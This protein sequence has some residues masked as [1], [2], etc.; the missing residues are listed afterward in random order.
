MNANDLDTD[1]LRLIDEPNTAYIATILPDGGPHTVPVWLGR[2][3]PHLVVLTSPGSQKSR[4]LRRDPR[5]ALSMTHRDNPF[6]STYLRGRVAGRIEDDRAWPIIDRIS[7]QYTGAPY[8]LRE[9][10]I[11]VLI[12]PER[13]RSPHAR[14]SRT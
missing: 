2:E 9:N 1:I 7:E 5:V 8:P 13:A 10:R 3:G 11:V 4:N 6:V 14:I 12:E